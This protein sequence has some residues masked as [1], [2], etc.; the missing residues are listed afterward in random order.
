LQWFNEVVKIKPN[1]IHGFGS[2]VVDYV[3]FNI[4]IYNQIVNFD[5]QNNHEL[6]LDRR[7]LTLTL[8]FAIQKSIIE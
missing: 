4:P 7:S 3:I 6:D 1:Y 5:I 2:D 8:D